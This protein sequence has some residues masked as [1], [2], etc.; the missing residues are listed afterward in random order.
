MN[1]KLS[2]LIIL[3]M[4][5]SAFAAINISLNDTALYTFT[6]DFYGIQYNRFAFKDSVA[7]NKLKPLNIKWIRQ[8][9]YPEDFHPEPGVWNWTILDDKINRCDSLGYEIVLCLFQSHDWFIGTPENGWWNYDSGRTEWPIAARELAKRYKDQVR[10]FLLFDEVNYMYP[11]QDD[12]MTFKTCAELY[13][14]ATREIKALDPTLLCGGPSGH[15][16]WECGHWG[17]YVMAEPGADTLLDLIA[18]NQFITWGPDE[19]DNDVMDHT[20]WYEEGPNKIRGMMGNDFP[21]MLVLD[22]YNANGSWQN[23]GELWTDPRNTNHFG[24][25]YHALAKLHSAKG[26]YDI[27][28]HWETLGGYGILQWFPHYTPTI[29]Y[30]TWRF[31]IESADMISG[32]ILI[33]ANTNESPRNVKH[34]NSTHVNSYT[35]QPFAIKTADNNYNVILINKQSDDKNL[36]IQTPLGMQS[37]SL[38]YFDGEILYTNST[39]IMGDAGDSVSVFCPGMSIALVKFSSEAYVGIKDISIPESCEIINAYPNPFNPKIAISYQ[40]SAN[41]KIK[42]S[43]YN[44]AGQKVT[45]IL[46]ETKKAGTHE[47]SWDASGHPSGIY[48][49]KLTSNEMVDVKKVLLVK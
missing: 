34:M 27:T 22:A 32:S 33:D 1:K 42:L 24:G 29:P 2:I 46:K 11:E 44:S 6:E 16:G 39:P 9:A 3:T 19:S 36:K 43:I 8:W 4:F 47:I 7:T 28:L 30:Y 37:Y 17:N 21:G 35:V 10:I 49:I 12:Y 38:S 18:P 25:I 14:E 26:G 20:I 48:L 5:A 45:N 23:N 31:L 13:V 15:S 40:L 41:S